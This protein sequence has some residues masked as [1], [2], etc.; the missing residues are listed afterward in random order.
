MQLRLNKISSPKILLSI[1]FFFSKTPQKNSGAI[2]RTSNFYYSL[3]QA[4][5]DRRCLA[6]LK[7]LFMSE[8]P[9]PKVS[10]ARDA[11]DINQIR[12]KN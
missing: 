9:N 11:L 4:G 2:A 8:W 10:A 1:T 7:K 6:D 5:D 3:E 12:K